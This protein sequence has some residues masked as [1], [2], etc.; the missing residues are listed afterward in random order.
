MKQQYEDLG[1]LLAKHQ[2]S[3][4][5]PQ[6]SL[7]SILPEDLVKKQQILEIDG[8]RY[9]VLQELPPAQSDDEI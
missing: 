5:R 9:L 2:A 7:S 6:E 3:M 1:E 8:T 4:G